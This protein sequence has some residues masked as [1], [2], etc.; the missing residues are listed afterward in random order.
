MMKQAKIGFFALLALL[1]GC[2]T[3]NNIYS[4]YHA[5]TREAPPARASKRTT[6]FFLVD[7]MSVPA[8]QRVMSQGRVPSIRKFFLPGRDSFQ[9]GRAVFPTLTYPNIS[10]ILTTRPIDEQPVIGNQALLDGRVVNF[11]SP[12]SNGFLNQTL[13]PLSVFER[14][15]ERNATSISLAHSFGGGATV[16]YSRDFEAGVAYL[17][18]NYAYI[19]DK[20]LDSANR[21]LS[22]MDAAAWP[23]LIFIHLVGV[24]AEA[25]AH[26]P[27]SKQALDYLERLDGRLAK[28]L[29]ILR[30][31]QASGKDVVT[32]MT[33]DHG[34]TA[35]PRFADV[36]GALRRNLSRDTREVIT[37]NQHRLISLHFPV[38]WSDERRARYLDAARALPGVEL[39]MLR[40][41][42]EV[43]VQ[44][45]TG[46]NPDARIRYERANCQR[47]PYALAFD[48]LPQGSGRRVE[49]ASFSGYQCP[50]V[51]ERGQGS[52]YDPYFASNV[53]AYFH[54]P[55]HP[56][57][58]ITARPGVSFT[59]EAL[60]QHGG[61]TAEEVI[62]PV[63]MRGAEL[64]SA[65]QVVPTYELLKFV[66][67]PESVRAD[68]GMVE[69]LVGPASL[70]ASV[71][72]RE[73]RSNR[74]T[75]ELEIASP[76]SR[77][78]LN[79]SADGATHSLSSD[80]T[81]GLNGEWHQYWTK[82]VSTSLGY[83][84]KF[85]QVHDD[86]EGAIYGNAPL[87]QQRVFLGSAY[88]FGEREKLGLSLGMSQE[89]F[90]H[91]AGQ[92]LDQVWI[93]EVMFMSRSRVLSLAVGDLFLG[94]GLGF[95]APRE[96]AG[97]SVNPGF[98]QV[99]SFGFERPVGNADIAGAALSV[100]HQTQN[101]VREDRSG[102]MVLLSLS[103]GLTFI[104]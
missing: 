100:E 62:V 5:A 49:L 20:L 95:L 29:D 32:L 42:N 12:L 44:S 27:L 13:K 39:T 104:D 101:T 80:P 11:E 55:Y 83:Q 84:F 45:A 6:V 15:T 59:N 99:F 25:H 97:L 91:L 68:H 8:L 64:R 65:G 16:Q 40:S 103:Y 7:G 63:L 22:K 98:K 24:D 92:Q 30:E 19:D 46:H 61:L 23:E 3:R 86:A 73:K 34:F 79:T 69:E 88:H 21:L 51:L 76:I 102:M 10:S 2:A 38:A 54:S 85:S 58:V 52:E 67:A 71:R 28:T 48:R 78:S 93:P 89:F 31:A 37:L 56:D 43:L 96:V 35:T 66:T 74:L 87:F 47:T 81:L 26:G 75:Q 36:A 90:P 41:R 72:E 94:G 9:V 1:A 57:A 77:W 53:A 33:A 4:D 17:T 14:L 50:E 82:L 18:G 70:E 60:G